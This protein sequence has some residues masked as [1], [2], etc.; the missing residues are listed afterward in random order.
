MSDKQLKEQRLKESNGAMR[1]ASGEV[2][3]PR[4]LVCFLYCLARDRMPSGEIETLLDGMTPNVEG[5]VFTNGWLAE[6]AKYTADR[7]TSEGG[8]L[9]PLPVPLLLFCPQCRRQHIDEPDPPEQRGRADWW[10]NPPHATHLCRFCG[11]HWRVSDMPTTGVATINT[12]GM[13][14]GSPVPGGGALLDR[15]RWVRWRKAHF[16]LRAGAWVPREK[17]DEPVTLESLAPA[18][19]DA[20][21]IEERLGKLES[22]FIEAHFVEPKRLVLGVLEHEALAKAHAPKV[23]D[24]FSLHRGMEVVRVGVASWMELQGRGIDGEEC[25]SVG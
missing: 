25:Y 7:L 21:Q 22:Q 12:M 24:V 10:P 5:Y 9:T 18:R 20:Q 2:V 17:G 13:N 11:H 19:R 15:Q 14:D 1:K 8:G 16:G 6:W 4:L 23:G 3:D